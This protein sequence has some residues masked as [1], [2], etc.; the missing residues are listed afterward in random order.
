VPKRS[1]SCACSTVPKQPW[2]SAALILGFM[3]RFPY[4]ASRMGDQA[5][6]DADDNVLELPD[7][8]LGAAL[9]LGFAEL[10]AWHPAVA[11]W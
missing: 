6:V 9:E 1:M 8:Y 3:Q 2:I 11:A 5:V 4:D 10:C 7:Y